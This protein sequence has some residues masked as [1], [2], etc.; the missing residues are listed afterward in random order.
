M[1]LTPECIAAAYE[2]FR[3]T[4]PGN[5]WNLPPSDE[6]QI[7]VLTTRERM[8][9]VRDGKPIEL[10]V[11]CARVAYTSTL[12]PVVGHEVC[13]LRAYAQGAKGTGHGYLWKRAAKQMARHHGFDPKEL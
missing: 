7:I 13:H 1:H 2:Y 6:L 3:H 12:L 11:S 9:H 5:K 10:A 4:P 8:G